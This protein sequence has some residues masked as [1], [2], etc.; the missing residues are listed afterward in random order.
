MYIA[1]PKC[2]AHYKIMESLLGIDG[3]TVRCANCENTWFQSPD[4]PV[5]IADGENP[6]ITDMVSGEKITYER[7][8]T[9]LDKLINEDI[10]ISAAEEKPETSQEEKTEEIP[11]E[12]AKETPEETSEEP[13]VE[14]APIE[15]FDENANNQ[16]TEEDKE[17]E[18]NKVSQ[19]DM[20]TVQSEDNKNDKVNK[21]NALEEDLPITHPSEDIVSQVQ[22]VLG[23]TPDT[24]NTPQKETTEQS[25]DALFSRVAEEQDNIAKEKE[26]KQEEIK[27]QTDN[28]KIEDEDFPFSFE[29]TRQI[30][31]EMPSE[32]RAKILKGLGAFAIAFL[33]IMFF[34]AR[35]QIA[36]TI[37]FT[38]PIYEAL[39][40]EAVIPGEDLEILNVTRRSYEVDFERKMEISG[41]IFNKTEDIQDLPL[42]TVELLDK[43]TGYLQDKEI[44]LERTEIKAKERIGFNIVIDTPARTT[45]YVLVTF[46]KKP[47][48]KD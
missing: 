43:E 44:E 13:E 27:S 33:F 10:S 34:A 12:K 22:A 3:R 31:M 18:E 1:C 36:K 47:K 29:K 9:S 28:S 42:V 46:K 14:L 30:V 5:E 39:N 11:G 8:E 45:K 32:K 2:K 48:K 16:E 17:V 38:I 6:E 23:T 21:D 24:D 19:D 15:E 40:V 26:Q 25:T 4:N 37:R 35:Y 20:N 41:F 7:K